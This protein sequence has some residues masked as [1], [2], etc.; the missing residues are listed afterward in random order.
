MWL[1][2]GKGAWHFVTLPED[3][4]HEIR[5]HTGEQKTFGSVAVKVKCGKSE[6]KTSLFRDKKSG[7][8]L[9]PVKASVREQQGLHAGDMLNVEIS[10]LRSL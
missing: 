2:N 1:W 10:L 4:A 3:L 8:Y 6:W 7:S 5:F 9:L